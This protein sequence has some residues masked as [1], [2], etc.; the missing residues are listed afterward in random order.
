MS[1][2]QLFLALLCAAGCPRYRVGPTAG[3]TAHERTQLRAERWVRFK[4]FWG[5]EGVIA[6]SIGTKAGY[7]LC[8]Q[9]WPSC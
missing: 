3:G 7:F 8:S 1:P 5:I 9:M 6:P 2:V 4:A